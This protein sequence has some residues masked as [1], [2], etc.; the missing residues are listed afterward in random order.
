[1][2]VRIFYK[3]TSQYKHC[4]PTVADRCPTGVDKGFVAQKALS[5]AFIPSKI[6][7]HVWSRLLEVF[8]NGNALDY[9]SHLMPSCMHV[10]SMHWSR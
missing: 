6:I 2:N 4:R 3:Q 10:C 7:P 9:Y 5:T 1:M 8:L